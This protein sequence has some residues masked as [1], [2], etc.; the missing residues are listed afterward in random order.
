MFAISIVLIRDVTAQRYEIFSKT[1]EELRYMRI[2]KYAILGLL[3]HKSMSGY[4]LS[5]EFESALNEFW[6]AKHSQIYPELKKLT[7]EGMITYVTAI[8]GNVL[9]KK[10]Y[11]ITEEGRKSFLKWLAEDQPIAP[12]P[13]DTFR[14]R[15]FFFSDLP[16]ERRIEMFENQLT[17]HRLRKT[18]LEKKMTKFDGMPDRD[19]QEFGDY[20]VLTGAIMRQ[21]MLC[22]WLEKCIR[23]TEEENSSEQSISADE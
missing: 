6:S 10:I 8:T 22:E 20:L 15:I 13:K 14:L 5:A 11:T 21:E 12:T 18:Y 17:Q 4:E 3:N 9:E 19:S 7:E 2:L 16:V 1:E 23:L